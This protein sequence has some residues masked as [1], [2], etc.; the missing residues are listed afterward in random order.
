ML[1]DSQGHNESRVEGAQAQGASFKGALFRY[2]LET[3]HHT[4]SLLHKKAQFENVA[5]GAIYG[6]C[7]PADSPDL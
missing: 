6:C 5:S 3:N 4:Y 1:S 2:F 7:G